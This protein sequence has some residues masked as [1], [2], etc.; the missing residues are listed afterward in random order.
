M[1]DL[2]ADAVSV[3]IA[4][5]YVAHGDPVAVLHPD[6]AA[7]VPVQISIIRFIAVDGDVLE[8]DIRD[9]LAAEQRKQ[10]FHCRFPH[11]PDVLTQP[12]IELEPIA[13]A[14]NERSLDHFGATG[15]R[16]LCTDTNAI[17]DLEAF[18]VDER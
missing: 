13:V 8:G 4:R 9:V 7:V 3:V 12:G 16:V 15:R 6:A 18:G 1:A 5:D 11:E 17:A 14:S 10:C 2:P